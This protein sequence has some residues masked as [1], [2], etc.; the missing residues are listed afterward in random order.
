M[1]QVVALQVTARQAELDP[2]IVEMM[3]VAI[4]MAQGRPG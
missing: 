4:Q 3:R 1:K 2:R